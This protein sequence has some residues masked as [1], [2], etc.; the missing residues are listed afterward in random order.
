M[1]LPWEF[2]FVS[3]C[4]CAGIQNIIE[5]FLVILNLL[6]TYGCIDPYQR[7]INHLL[8]YNQI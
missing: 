1:L 3:C 5:G 4:R 2:A 6:G 7:L 8:A